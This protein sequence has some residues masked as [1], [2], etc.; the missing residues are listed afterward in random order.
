MKRE[1]PLRMAD[2]RS[3]TVHSQG[4]KE[5]L[6]KKGTRLIGGNGVK[7]YFIFLN[8]GVSF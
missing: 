2:I 5:I 7:L 4:E 3:D 6:E 8:T 1:K